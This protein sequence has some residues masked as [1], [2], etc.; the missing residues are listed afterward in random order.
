MPA[1]L[2]ELILSPK[3]FYDLD[4]RLGM[5]GK[6]H[7]YDVISEARFLEAKDLAVGLCG[8]DDLPLLAGIDGGEHRSELIRPTRL[9]L[10]EAECFAVESDDIDL[11]S[12]L[13]AF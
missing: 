8:T 11:T 10:D 1:A 13:N 2:S 9:H 3:S 7:C 6:E 4:R 5:F 12:D